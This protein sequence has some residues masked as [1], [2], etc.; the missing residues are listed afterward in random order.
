MPTV[1]TSL[2]MYT[3]PHCCKESQHH[4]YYD[5]KAGSEFECEKCEKTIYVLRL[6]TSIEV[7]LS[8]DPEE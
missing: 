5:V 2:P 8:T 6:D 4:D 7:E 1:Y 3:C